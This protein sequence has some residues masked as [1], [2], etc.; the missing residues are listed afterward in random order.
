MERRF[1]V[2]KWKSNE[3]GFHQDQPNPFLTNNF[4]ALSLAQQSRVFL[5]LCGKTLDI[6][7]LLANG[8]RVV[9]VELV[10]TAIEQ[11]FSELGLEPDISPVG[12]LIHYHSENIDI[13]VGD[14]FDLSPDILGQVDGVY[15]RAALVALP[16]EIR[17]RYTSHLMMITRKAPQL[18]IS[19]HYDQSLMAGPPFSI[20]N[21]E[22]EQHYAAHYKLTHLAHVEVPGGLKGKCPATENIWLLSPH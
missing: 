9:G 19:Y 2:E 16:E 14:F 10:E 8:Y 17:R 20:P 5:P 13:Y 22:V 4:S 6:S 18:L 11:L 12:P 3:I 15:D 1:W 7:W 21:A